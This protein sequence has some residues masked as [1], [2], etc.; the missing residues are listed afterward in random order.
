MKLWMSLLLVTLALCCYEANSLVCPDLITKVENF[1]LSSNDKFTPQLS[2]YD[3]P[4]TSVE[5]TLEV[6]KCTDKLSHGERLRLV[7]I[8]VITFSFI[9]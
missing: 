9:H 7:S 1:L 6:K 2:T 8:L 4:L 5:A 3:V